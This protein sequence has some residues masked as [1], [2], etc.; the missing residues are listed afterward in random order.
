[1]ENFDFINKLLDGR[2]VFGNKEMINDRIGLI[3]VYST[4]IQFFNLKTDIKN[5]SGDGGSGSISIKPICILKI[6]GDIV[7]IIS[8]NDE[9][10][11]E[12][13]LD[14]ITPLFSNLDI[15]SLFKGFKS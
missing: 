9:V 3:P 14:N 12:G 15:N 8:F 5:N 7:D 4:K 11:H 6:N 1:M 10:T 13:I 2:I